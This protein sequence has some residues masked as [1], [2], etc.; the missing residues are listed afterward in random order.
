MQ[1]QSA[2]KLLSTFLTFSCLLYHGL[3]ANCAANS[4]T[5]QQ[6]Q[7]GFGNPPKFM[8]EVQN[9]LPYVPSYQ[10]PF[11]LRKLSSTS[12]QSQTAQSATL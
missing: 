7:V 6:T 9:K 3:G 1:S 11:E 5:V 12:G 10:Y 4:P 8:V 2:S